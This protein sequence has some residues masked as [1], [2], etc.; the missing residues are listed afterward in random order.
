MDDGDRSW[1]VKAD[2]APRSVRQRG[3]DPAALEPLVNQIEDPLEPWGGKTA[4]HAAGRET[5]VGP[6]QMF[7]A[8]GHGGEPILASGTIGKHPVSSRI[9]PLP[10]AALR[11]TVRR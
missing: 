5:P 11:Q 7:A 2:P 3:V 9:P 8:R 4:D 6:D 1:P 10:S